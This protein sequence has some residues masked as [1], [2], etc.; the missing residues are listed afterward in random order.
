MPKLD[1][2]RKTEEFFP[3]IHLYQL[4]TNLVFCFFTSAWFLKQLACRS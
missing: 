3:S 2:I 4:L 1:F